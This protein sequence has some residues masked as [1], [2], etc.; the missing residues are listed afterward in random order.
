M[1]EQIG[2]MSLVDQIVKKMLEN[3]LK[4]KQFNEDIIKKLEDLYKN[5][6][7]KK[8]NKIIVVIKPKL[9]E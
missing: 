5:G 6:N 1:E 2:K 3:S 9:E 8:P 4:D 7:L